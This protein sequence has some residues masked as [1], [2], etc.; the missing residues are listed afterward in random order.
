MAEK[1]KLVNEKYLARAIM[2]LYMDYGLSYGKISGLLGY[3]SPTSVRDIAM[4]ERSRIRN[5]IDTKETVEQ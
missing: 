3:K 4:R 5:N 2:F 1:T